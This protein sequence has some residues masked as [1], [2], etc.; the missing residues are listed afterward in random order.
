MKRHR[1]ATAVTTAAAAALG[2]AAGMALG[3]MSGPSEHK[4][5]GVE[6][7]GKLDAEMIA[8]QTGLDGY[9]MQLR[10]ITIAPG[11]QIAQHGH[12]KRPGLVK[13]I[14]GDWVEGRPEGETTFSADGKDSIL[15]D[16]DTVHWFHNRGDT[17]ATAIVCDLNPV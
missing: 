16:A 2:L 4:G 17:P 11:G 10:A 6:A 5:L 12:E 14:S 8:R 1:F 3:Q 13:V 15:E 7:L 9:M